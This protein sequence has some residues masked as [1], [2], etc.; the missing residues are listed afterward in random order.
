MTKTTACHSISYPLTMNFSVEHGFAAALTLSQM[1]KIN[2]A[3]VPELEKIEQLFGGAFEGWIS[4][5][6]KGI[7]ELSLSAFGI[8]KNDIDA[9]A[10]GA[11]T[12]GRMDNNPAP[13]EIGSVKE[14]LKNIL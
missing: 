14:V 3:A 7:Q 8:G 12:L 6:S 10:K 1:M 2:A 5:V 4:K 11:F 13:M 9:I